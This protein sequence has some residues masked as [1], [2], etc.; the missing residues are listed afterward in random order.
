MKPAFDIGPARPEELPPLGALLVEVYSSLEGFPTPAQ[1]PAYYEM[2]AQVGRFAERPKV[3]ILVARLPTGGLAGGVLYF[4]DMAHY[5]SGGA[6]TQVRDAAG[7]RLLGVAP[8]MRGAG[9][10]RALTGACVD[11]ARA[12]GHAQVI[13]HTTRAMATAWTMYERMGFQR[14]ADLDFLQQ[15]LPVFG[16]RLAL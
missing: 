16:F 1:Q 15:D 11:V 2:L 3:R 12:E 5:G 4:G 13:L 6:A 7:I 14:S 8:S 10:G 9:L